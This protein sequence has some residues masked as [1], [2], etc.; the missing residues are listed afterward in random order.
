MLKA[1]TWNTLK[2]EKEG[3]NNALFFFLTHSVISKLDIP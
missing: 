2:D 1:E 3:V